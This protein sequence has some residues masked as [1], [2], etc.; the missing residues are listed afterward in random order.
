MGFANIIEGYRHND[1][2][3]LVYASSSPVY[4]SNTK[5]L[6]SI[7]DNVNHPIK[8]TLPQKNNELI[9]NAYSHRYYLP[10]T[11]LRFLQFMIHGDRPDM[12]LQKVA[13]AIMDGKPIQLFN[14][15]NHR[16]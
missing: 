15:G 8:F 7:H 16:R 13:H 12:A 10:T 5:I 3:H 14:N 4:D 6:F 2:D 11:G 1:I 9:A